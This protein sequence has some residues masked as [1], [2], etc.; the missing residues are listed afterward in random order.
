MKNI[1]KILIAMLAVVITATAVI[2]P[3]MAEGT[4]SAGNAPAASGQ[5]LPQGGMAQNGPQGRI[6]GRNDCRNAPQGQPGNGM[7]GPQGQP[8]SGMN[9]PQGQPGNG[10][11]GPQGQPGNGMNGPQGQA[12][13][14]NGQAPEAPAQ[15]GNAENG[16]A[17]EAPADGDSTDARTGATPT[18]PTEGEAPANGEAPA[19]GQ[20]PQMPADGGKFADLPERID[21]AALVTEGTISQETCEAIESYLQSHAPAAP[22]EGEA[23]ANGEAPAQGQPPQAPAD[24]ERPD[25]LAELLEQNVITQAEYDAISGAQAK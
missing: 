20:P 1:R 16:D 5:M 23:P 11:N 18:A 25:L 9:G 15:G 2:V 6:S 10:M 8:G 12:P 3:A 21:F 22:A 7:N 4:A 19:Q 14:M 13:Q 24:G 17:P